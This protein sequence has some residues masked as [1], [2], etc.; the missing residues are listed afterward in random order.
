M[1]AHFYKGSSSQADFDV[2]TTKTKQL[3]SNSE[4]GSCSSCYKQIK[5]FL[6]SF[7]VLITLIFYKVFKLLNALWSRFLRCQAQAAQRGLETHV[8][9]LPTR[10]ACDADE[11]DICSI[12]LDPFRTG[13]ELRSLNCAH[14]F[15]QRCIDMWLLDAKRPQHEQLPSCPLCKAPLTAEACAASPARAICTTPERLS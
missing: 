9:K 13:E 4:V 11:A 14:E 3:S 12:C 5:A 8:S 1:D 15:H 6:T 7:F 10:K 2:G